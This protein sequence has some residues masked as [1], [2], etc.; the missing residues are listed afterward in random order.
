MCVK[1]FEYIYVIYRLLCLP[2][3]EF[4]W[5]KYISISGKDTEE[6]YKLMPRQLTSIPQ[7]R[8]TV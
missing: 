2:Q 7:T 3:S 5:Q 6:K 8:H 1:S 4:T